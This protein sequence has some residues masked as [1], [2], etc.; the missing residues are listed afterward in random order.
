MA[1]ADQL[2]ARPATSR[3]RSASPRTH[4]ERDGR[5]PAA[6]L[7]MRLKPNELIS[8]LTQHY[9]RV[10]ARARPKVTTK[11]ACFTPA[12]KAAVRIRLG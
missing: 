3:L 2:T 7:A 11:I 8:L 4:I 12:G 5:K 6:P 10:R 9:E 1:I